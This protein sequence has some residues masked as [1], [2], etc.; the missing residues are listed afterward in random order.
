LFFAANIEP[1]IAGYNI[2]R[3]SDPNLPRESWTKL[4]E[5]LL[6]RTSFQDERVESGRRYYYYLTAIDQAGNVSAPSEVVSEE[7]P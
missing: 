2:Y 4:N 5:E 3:S 6:T 1:D 7:V